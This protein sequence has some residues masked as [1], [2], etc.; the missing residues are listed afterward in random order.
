MNPD[1]SNESVETGDE[2]FKARRPFQKMVQMKRV[3]IRFTY[4]RIWKIY[5][6]SVK[7]SKINYGKRRSGYIKLL[8]KE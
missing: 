3:V 1:E 5:A 7:N 6:I 4:A 2:E 8:L